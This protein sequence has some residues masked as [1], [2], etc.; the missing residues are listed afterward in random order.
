MQSEDKMEQQRIQN[1]LWGLFI[2]DSLAMPAHWYYNIDNIKTDF[3]GAIKDYQAP[4]HPHPES[5]M[6]GM[7]YHPD[8]ESANK[9]GRLYDILHD[10]VRF[11][12]TPYSTLAI[13]IHE[14]ETEHGNRSPNIENRFHYHHGLVKG[15][16]TLGAHLVRVLMRS[17]ISGGRYDDQ[18]FLEHFI[19]HM[20]T[21]GLNRDPY[22]EIY[23]RRWFENYALGLPVHC[24][25]GMQRAVWSIGSLGGCIR[26]L[27]VAL[28]TASAYQGTGLAIEHQNLTHRSENVSSA[29]HILV[30][31]LFDLASGHD[32][33]A[34]LDKYAGLVHAPRIRGDELFAMYR[35]NN[36]PG[37]I[38]KEI[39]WQLHTHL[40]REPLNLEELTAMPEA[41]MVERLATACYPEHG[42]PLLLAL[43]KK[44]GFAVKDS[45]LANANAGGDNVHRGM[46]MGLLVGAAAKEIP[47]DLIEGLKDYQEIGKEIKAFSEMAVTGCNF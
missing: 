31:L 5:F 28:L 38:P 27:V 45:L 18:P 43:M 41:A 1:G 14:Q 13:E 3:D 19:D 47:G 11:Y 25:A 7:D 46:I 20:T 6:V 37:N 34:A 4:P 32:S 42:L 10:H 26:P 22:T 9:S 39:M 23:L 15:E 24:C 44:H 16:N 33:S 30:P 8:I 40:E 36:G 35:K 12:D 21:P 29:L 17:V 2:G